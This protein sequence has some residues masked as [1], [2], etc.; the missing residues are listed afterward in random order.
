M[1][2]SPT[3]AFRGLLLQSEALSGLVKGG[4][5]VGPAS[6]TQVE[7]YAIEV[8]S[9]GFVK[10]ELYLPLIRPRFLVTIIGPEL[11]TVERI[12]DVIIDEFHY[13]TLA[14]QRKTV[15]LDNGEGYLIH[16]TWMIVGPKQ[17]AETDIH[18]YQRERMV[19]AAIIGTDPIED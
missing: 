11:D 1:T 2:L 16:T 14:S 7:N 15:T 19:M 17:E 12:K 18:S 13:N 8:A 5:V 4:I 10:N 6:Q 9:S 3:E